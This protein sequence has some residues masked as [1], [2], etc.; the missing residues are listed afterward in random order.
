MD[1]DPELF[2][3][4]SSGALDGGPSVPAVPQVSHLRI[5]SILNCLHCPRHL[6]CPPHCVNFVFQGSR[7]LVSFGYEDPLS[8]MLEVRDEA[9]RE[10]GRF[11]RHARQSFPITRKKENSKLKFL[12]FV[13]GPQNRQIGF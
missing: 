9:V 12:H 13:R 10:R 11:V 2:P 3:S 7:H 1:P 8:G 4:P 5:M 6:S